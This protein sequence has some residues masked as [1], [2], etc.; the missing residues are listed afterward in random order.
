MCSCDHGSSN[1]NCV[2]SLAS[3]W[4]DGFRMK[5]NISAYCLNNWCL[6]KWLEEIVCWWCSFFLYSLRTQAWCTNDLYA[7]THLFKKLCKNCAM[8]SLSL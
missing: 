4:L 7:V 8:A 1:E 2:R 5:V 6:K 3:S